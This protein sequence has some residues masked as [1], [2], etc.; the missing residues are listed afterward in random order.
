MQTPDLARK[1]GVSWLGFKRDDLIS[2]LHGGTKV[3]KLD[4]LLATEPF[5]SAPGWASMG[6]IGSGHLVALTAAAKELDREIVAGCFWIPTSPRVIENL[7]FVAGHLTRMSYRHS[8]IGL[9]LRYP[10]LLIGHDH[11]SYPVIPPGASCAAGIV[12]IVRAGLELVAQV[13]AGILPPPDR[14]Y[15]PLGSGGTVAGLA[16]AFGMI[17]F[18]CEI[19]AVA[20]V[21]RL[22]AHRRRIACLIQRARAYLVDH[23]VT[24]AADAIAVPVH[25]DRTQ[26]GRGYGYPTEAASDLCALLA[27]TGLPLEVVYSGKAMA[28]LAADA[29]AGF[30]GQA[31]LWVTPQSD[32]PLG[33]IDD[34][35]THLPRSLRIR[36]DDERGWA[37][38]RIFKVAALGGVG[39]LLAGRL[40]YTDFPQWNGETL[41]DCEAHF[42][43]AVTRALL[44]PAADE[45]AFA[46]VPI[47]V[48]HYV[49]HFTPELRRELHLALAS[50]EHGT[51]VLT[52]RPS[53][54]SALSPPSAVA[55]LEK[56]RNRG[57]LQRQLYR[58]VRDLCMLGYYQQTSTWLAIQYDGPMSRPVTRKSR[59][60]VMLAKKGTTPQGWQQ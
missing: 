8:R 45:G 34:W 1:I 3:R 31:L 39:L 35:R 10:S 17:G 43:L 41:S 38:R 19:R 50:I 5:A 25:L 57:G 27:E 15:V 20:A 23:G 21:E 14:I 33:A 52:L 53:R 58:A 46:Q 29:G 24:A 36:L 44:P 49:R 9:A 4:Y 32:S 6:A 47:N 16:L 11:A 55:Y 60:A 28:A 2:Q 42:L 48:D 51:T 22:F 7:A 13:D 54:M 30:S 37:R 59:Y 18:R 26:L 56:L 12:G 40:S